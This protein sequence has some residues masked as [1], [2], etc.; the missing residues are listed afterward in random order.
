M[1][2][3]RA[4]GCK[5]VVDFGCGEGSWIKSLLLDPAGSAVAAV[6]GVDES[7]T[8][9]QRG[10]KRVLAALMKHH[11][12]EDLRGHA[13][14][15]IQLLQVRLPPRSVG[16]RRSIVRAATPDSDLHP[17]MLDLILRCPDL[18]Y[19]IGHNTQRCCRTTHRHQSPRCSLPPRLGLCITQASVLPTSPTSCAACLRDPHASEVPGRFRPCCGPGRL[20]TPRPRLSTAGQRTRCDACCACCAGQRDAGAASG[21]RGV[22]GVARLRCCGGVRGGGARA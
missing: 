5:T 9:L 20:R 2:V 13:V 1:Q 15:A 18:L 7:P 17:L 10:C 21:G 16:L 19:M 3:V 14:P 22:G 12:E 6:A 11:A 8:A 4:H